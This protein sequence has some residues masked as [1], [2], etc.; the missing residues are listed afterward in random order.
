MLHGDA[1]QPR[2]AGGRSPSS[3]RSG[4]CSPLNAGSLGMPAM[5]LS[6]AI[7][8]LE[9]RSIGRGGEPT[10]GLALDL[11]SAEWRSGDRERELRLHLLFLSWYCNFEPPFLTGFTQTSFPSDELTQLFQDVYK[12]FGDE[13]LDDVE[14]LYVVGLMALL[15]PYLLGENEATWQARSVAFEERYRLLA[16]QGLTA[17]HFEGRGAYGNYF[18]GQVVV[19]GGYGCPTRCCS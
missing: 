18:A 7:L 14:C 3:L 2:V 10:L 8:D 17:A 6:R 12:S 13:I 9:N 1:V 11:A 19:P 15:T 4:G 5:S 16:P